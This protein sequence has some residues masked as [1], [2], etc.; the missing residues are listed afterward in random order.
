MPPPKLQPLPASWEECTQRG[1]DRIDILLVTGDAYVD[2]PSFGVSLIGRFLEHYGYQVAILSQPRYDCPKD[3]QRFPAPRLFCG[4][5]AGNLDSIVANYTGNGK[6]RETD[7]YS[8][9]G[10]VWRSGD[11]NK[12]NRYRPDRASL[13]Y[14]NLARACYKNT[15]IVL[16]GLEA[17]LRRF[18]H[19]DYKQNRLRSSFLTD[20]KADLIVYGMGEH[21]VLDIARK[22]EA[23]RPLQGIR[24]SCERLTDRELAE[25]YPGWSTTRIKDFLLL[26]SFA[27]IQNTP[28]YFLDAELALDTHSRAGSS[29]IVLQKQ[30][31][32]WVVQHPATTALTSRELDTLYELPCTRQP[33]PLTPDVPAHRMI[34]DSVTI[35]RGCSGN[36]SFCAITR[37]QGATIQS[38]SVESV[39]REC[40]TIAASPS[41]TGTISDLGG[42]TANLYGTS[43][44]IGGCKKKDCLYPQLCRHLEIDEHRFLTLLQKVASL[45]NV[46]HVFISSGLRMELLLR[47]PSLLR[48]LLLHHIPG[49]MKIAPEH[50]NREVLRLMHKEPHLLL[51]KFIRHS[52]KLAKSL[53]KDLKV[54]PYVISAHP[55]CEEQHAAQLAADMAKLGLPLKQFQD[56]TPTPGTLSTAM[57]V[58][59]L[60]RIDKT[61][62]FVARNSSERMK[63]RKLLERKSSNQRSRQKRGQTA[64]S[65]RK[66][67]RRH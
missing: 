16:G 55:G 45:E 48:E 14:A 46:R 39:T 51:T 36:C 32:H 10:K 41:F 12:N 25:R 62:I 2:H 54:V 15:P 57:Y 56:F 47:T 7:A 18:V 1:W 6:V 44:A 43:C 58:T 30:Q 60:S 49:T 27:D 59:G 4:I 53:G 21:A 66:K 19:F 5:T 61:P 17:S 33:H 24:G 22:C 3:F 50:S 34:K 28:E 20:A 65:A 38:R 29:K 26:P 42:P 63:Q 11:K 8:P 52:R 67:T 40:A 31:T 23:G 64:I 13:I 37:H 9:Y 35:V